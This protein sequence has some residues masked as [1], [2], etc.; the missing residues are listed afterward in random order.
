MSVSAGLEVDWSRNFDYIAR[1]RS[2]TDDRQ[3]DN[4]VYRAARSQPYITGSD[5]TKLEHW[6]D[7]WA[8]KFNP[9]KCSLL[10]V[11]RDPWLKR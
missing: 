6:A 10:Q 11:K 1:K 5:L 7:T 4:G 2:A 8:M 9:S 3:T